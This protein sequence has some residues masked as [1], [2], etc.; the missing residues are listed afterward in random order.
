MSRL[1]RSMVVGNVK[2]G[3]RHASIFRLAHV[4][5][6]WHLVGA[7]ELDIF[8]QGIGTNGTINVGLGLFR[9]INSLGIATTLKIEDTIIVPILFYKKTIK[10][11]A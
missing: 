3:I 11:R 8:Q 4:K 10:R 6:I 2:N 5:V 7:N 9:Q 1:L